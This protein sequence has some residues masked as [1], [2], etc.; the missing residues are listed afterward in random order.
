M[1][2]DFINDLLIESN[3]ETKFQKFSDPHNKCS[4]HFLNNVFKIS[5]FSFNG[6]VIGTKENEISV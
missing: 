5:R 6:F 1:Q 3:R 2:L 4:T